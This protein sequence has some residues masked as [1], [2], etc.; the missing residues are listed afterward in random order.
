MDLA[1]GEVG[2]KR[3][4]VLRMRWG[5]LWRTIYGY[6]IRQDKENNRARQI[7]TVIWN[8]NRKPKTLAKRPRDL[9]PLA[10]DYLKGR[11]KQEWTDE[12]TERYNEAVKRWD[13]TEEGKKKMK[14][15]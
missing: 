11:N 4:E 2:L 7:V 10:T 8:A 3:E 13:M 12:D 9:W 1:L 6:W 5:D 14:P 15:I